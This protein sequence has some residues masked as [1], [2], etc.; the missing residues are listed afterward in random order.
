MKQEL[1]DSFVSCASDLGVVRIPRTTRIPPEPQ[2]RPQRN[3]VPDVPDV[4]EQ[5]PSVPRTRNVRA[6][7]PSI[8]PSP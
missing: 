8:Y 6:M 3:V 4:P 2:P 5:S 7:D 1:V